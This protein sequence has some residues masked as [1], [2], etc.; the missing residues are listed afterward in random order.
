MFWMK[1]LLL[2]LIAKIVGDFCSEWLRVKYFKPIEIP[3]SSIK[4]IL[5]KEEKTGDGQAE[6]FSDPTDEEYEQFKLE[7]KESWGIIRGLK[8]VLK[9][10]K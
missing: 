7:Q 8:K 2:L 6:Y 4:D 1:L 5:V 9:S 10:L 3:F